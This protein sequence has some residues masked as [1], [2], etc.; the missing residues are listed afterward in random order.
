[1]PSQYLRK[2]QCPYCGLWLIIA[3]RI[4]RVA[5]FNAD[6]IG[7]HRCNVADVQEWSDS[8]TSRVEPRPASVM[9][10]R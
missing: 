5:V 7:Y 1:M 8:L 9:L 4:G 10:N 2:T 3:R 6:G